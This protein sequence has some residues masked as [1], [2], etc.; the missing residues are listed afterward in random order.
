MKIKSGPI[1]AVQDARLRY[2][3]TVVSAAK[4]LEI[5]PICD[6]D[7]PRPSAW[8]DN[9][10][11]DF[12]SDLSSYLMQLMMERADRRRRTA[13]V[14]EGTTRDRL[15]SLIIRLRGEVQ[16]LDLPEARI[17]KVLRKIDE[18]EKALEGQ[19]LSFIAV[20]TVVFGIAAVLSDFDGAATAV[21]KIVYKIE[22]IVGQAKDTQDEDAASQMIETEKV[23]QLAP[24]RVQDRPSTAL[25]DDEIPF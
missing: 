22:Q 5:S 13:I 18:L 15:R 23:R 3:N 14:L 17:D 2:M 1:S 20:A 10:F 11:N 19:R 16:Q 25:P 21:Q 7:I 4:F 24:P 8:D 6:M 9:V 12:V